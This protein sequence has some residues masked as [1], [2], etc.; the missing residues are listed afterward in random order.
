MNKRRKDYLKA[1]NII[2][3][4]IPV[5]YVHGSSV[6]NVLTFFKANGKIKA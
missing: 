5:R 1:K 3:N 2:K 4:N 6:G